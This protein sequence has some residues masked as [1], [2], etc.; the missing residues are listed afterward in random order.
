MPAAHRFG[1]IGTGHGCWP[2]RNNSGG[3]TTVLVNGQGWHRVTDGW[4]SHCCKK[5][6]HPGNLAQGSPDVYADNL[7]VGRVGDPV[8][9][10]SKAFGASP[11]VYANGTGSPGGG[12]TI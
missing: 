5:S 2:P 3:S 9:C 12:Q 1:D 6:C 7:P 8:T 11:N 4:P 10:G